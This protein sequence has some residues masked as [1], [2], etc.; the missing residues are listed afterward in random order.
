VALVPQTIDPP[1]LTEILAVLVVVPG[2]LLIWVVLAAQEHL[3]KAMQA[4]LL[5]EMQ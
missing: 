5:A 4:D 3:A 2:R 1:H